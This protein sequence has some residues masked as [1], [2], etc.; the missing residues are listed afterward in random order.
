MN[1]DTEGFTVTSDR[2]YEPGEEISISYGS[3]SN[4]LLLTEYGF[5]LENNRNDAVPL[6]HVMLPQF[7]VEQRERLK[8]AGYLGKY[9]LDREGVCH[10]TQV[11]LRLLVGVPHGA[12]RSFVD[13]ETDGS[14]NQ[15]LVKARLTLILRDL[16]EQARVA[17]GGIGDLAGDTVE[18]TEYN[19]TAND[20]E[21]QDDQSHGSRAYAIEL[22]RR[23][24]EQIVQIVRGALDGLDL[25]ETW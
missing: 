3:H 7:S 21:G 11:A 14:E 13:G 23:R 22:L 18:N 19:D 6:D 24:W 5:I 25:Q 17:L 9:V 8:A 1:Y 15:V 4:D 10:R 2:S 12:W 16:E 20:S